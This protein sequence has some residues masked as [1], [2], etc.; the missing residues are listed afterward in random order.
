MNYSARTPSR[1]VF[2]AALCSVLLALE[3][4]AHAQV[5]SYQVIDLGTL[6][7]SSWHESNAL[8]INDNHEI[9][10]WARDSSGQTH[11][12]L[13]LYCPNYG[14]DAFTLHDLTDLAGL[15]LNGMAFDINNAGL[16]VGTQI[17]SS[18]YP[19]HAYIWDLATLPTLSSFELATLS[20]SYAEAIAY[21][22]N[23][24]YPALVV[25]T[26]TTA[27][28]ACDE[29]A[30]ENHGFRWL[31]ATSSSA[32]Y[33]I[34]PTGGDDYAE[35]RDVNSEFVPKAAGFSTSV[36][37]QTSCIPEARGINW[38]I[39]SSV[40]L[41]N[42][43]DNGTGY[44]S[45]AFGI[46]E[47]EHAV[48]LA[49]TGDSPCLIHAS[50]WS[51]P[52]ATLY[53]LGGVG[54]SGDESVAYKVTN[55]GSGG[56]L[57]A[58]G[59]NLTSSDAWRWYKN[60]SGTWSGLNLNTA[61]SSACGWQ[62]TEAFDVSDDGWIVGYGIVDSEIHGFLLKPIDCADLNGD[63]EVDGADLGILL[64]AWGCTT[65]CGCLVDFNVDGVIDGADLGTL[66]GYWGECP[67]ACASSF[68]SMSGGGGQ[69][70][71]ETALL[72]GL[73]ALGF[74]SL[75]AF[76]AWASTAGTEELEATLDWLSTFLISQQ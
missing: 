67:C 22:V 3:S 21:A 74:E 44:G 20:T 30:L 35:V 43:P 39:D 60:S 26:S 56:V 68:S 7:G 49:L 55:A 75:A 4:T 14:L 32:V 12:T 37:G 16:T 64:G 45:A 47:S 72:Q 76:Q 1:F 40:T 70:S 33:D 28:G 51:S 48:G 61:I 62:L 41:T 71:N 27:N 65:S 10:G 5:A 13:W 38:E 36:C 58:V 31:E 73:A 24:S 9:V 52:T 29:K 53:D 25:G 66:L 17:T 8:A 69:A 6:P 59:A 11:A 57:T 63:C 34:G 50:F 18:T 46:N 54:I 19:A 2:A 23:E 15:S 42:L